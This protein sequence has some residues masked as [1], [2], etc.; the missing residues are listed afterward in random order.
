MGWPYLRKCIAF[1]AHIS[2]KMCCCCQKWRISNSRSPPL[3]LVLE[4]QLIT[5]GMR[6][7]PRGGQGGDWIHVIPL[8]QPF[9]SLLLGLFLLEIFFSKTKISQMCHKPLDF[10]L[11]TEDF[12]SPYQCRPV[13][14][15]CA[16]RWLLPCT[17]DYRSVS[18]RGQSLSQCS[19][20][21]EQTWTPKLSWNHKNMVNYHLS[22]V[23]VT[24]VHL[25]DAC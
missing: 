12:D 1:L 9:L 15:R 25:I 23:K 20:S 2:S 19:S 18:C 16:W 13:R 7:R 5:E 8:S 24:K 22:K 17:V 11:I 6:R 3:G 21:V 14:V 10:L 4:S